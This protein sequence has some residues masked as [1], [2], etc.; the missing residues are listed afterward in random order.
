MR[1]GQPGVSTDVSA[2]HVPRF[3]IAPQTQST[4]SLDRALSILE[5]LS[6]SRFGLSLP[7]LVEKTRYPKSSVHCLLVT[8]DRRGY[9]R[10]NQRTGRYQL[11]LKFL[12]LANITLSGIP[13]REIAASHLKLLVDSTRLT[14]H[15]AILENNE[16]VLISKHSPAGVFGL[17]TWVG[18]RMEIHCTGL[19]KALIAYLPEEVIE[20]I[21]RERGM[22]RHND[23]TL[24]S[25][26]KLKADLAQTAAR[27]YSVDLEED[28]LGMCCIGA[29]IFDSLGT[30]VAAVSISGTT[31]EI[32][33]TGVKEL[34]ERVKKTAAHIGT[35]MA[36][37]AL[38][39]T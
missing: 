6:N 35:Q 33:S 21:I 38:P 22:P 11:G 9:V 5:L 24:S 13:L 39:V 12:S 14:A 2:G 1:T 37:S 34:G 16:A 25:F 18:K 7:Q 10:R 15:L 3:V 36:E 31:E 8:L 23:Q 26:K 19:G 27:G 28:E 20:R 30:P 4:P 17:A 29:P 32:M